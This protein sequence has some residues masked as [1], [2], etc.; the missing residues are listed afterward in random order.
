M[1]RVVSLSKTCSFVVKWEKIEKVRVLGIFKSDGAVFWIPI[2]N[3]T[4]G[5]IFYF[6]LIDAKFCPL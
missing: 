6:F 1:S 2:K 4:T 3:R 5:P